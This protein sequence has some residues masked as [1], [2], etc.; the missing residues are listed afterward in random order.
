MSRYYVSIEVSLE[1]EAPNKEV[2]EDVLADMVYGFDVDE[3]TVHLLD[4]NII[5]W[6]ITEVEE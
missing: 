6:T 3:E 4:E 1:L 5:D 2:L